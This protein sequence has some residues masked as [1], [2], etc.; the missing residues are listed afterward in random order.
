MRIL[1]LGYGGLDSSFHIVVKKGSYR[2]QQSISKR[3]HDHYLFN[4]ISNM[5]FD[6]HYAWLKSYMGLGQVHGFLF[7]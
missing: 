4:I 3:V 5:A 6:L 1:S 7:I 2:L